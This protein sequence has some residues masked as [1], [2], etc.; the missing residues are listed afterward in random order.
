MKFDGNKFF[1]QPGVVIPIDKSL[2]ETVGSS[3]PIER[4][5]QNLQELTD[6]NVRMKEMLRELEELVDD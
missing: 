3:M 4:L 2:T 5:K 1:R 6:L